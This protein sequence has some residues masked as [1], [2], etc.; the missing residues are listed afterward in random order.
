LKSQHKKLGL[1]CCLVILCGMF[2]SGCFVS[3][4]FKDMIRTPSIKGDWYN[5]ETK[6][7]F[8]LKDD[9]KFTM[10][11]GK[12]TANTGGTYTTDKKEI[13]LHLEYTIT[14]DGGKE[15]WDAGSK[16]G[17]KGKIVLPYAFKSDGRMLV[18]SEGGN[19]YFDKIGGETVEVT[20]EN[21]MGDWDYEEGGLTLAFKQDNHYSIIEDTENSKEAI[22]TYV[23]ENTQLTLKGTGADR[24]FTCE[25]VTQDRLLLTSDTGQFYY[26]RAK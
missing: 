5:K 1:V 7:Y 8:S 19:L 11:Y 23:L 22:G 26:E 2:T 21:L 3:D 14:A 15:E 17:E 20:N 25:F 16:L 4:I 9:G 13:T 18:K 6:T 10:G 12:G 24:V